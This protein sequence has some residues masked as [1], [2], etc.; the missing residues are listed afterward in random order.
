M[1]F[2]Q[3]GRQE[4][5]GVNDLARIPKITRQFAIMTHRPAIF[6]LAAIYTP[7]L[8]N[9][10]LSEHCLAGFCDIWPGGHLYG[11][12]LGNAGLTAFQT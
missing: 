4:F 6:G 11:S 7:R 1:H 8:G 12:R 2:P 5:T 9:A 10:G 3:R